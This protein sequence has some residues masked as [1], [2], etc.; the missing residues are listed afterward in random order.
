MNSTGL[1]VLA[2][3]DDRVVRRLLRISLSGHGMSLV[4]AETGAIGLDRLANDAPDLVVLD[5]GLPD[6]NGL[7]VLRH[8]RERSNIPIVVLSNTASV[9]AKIEALDLG[10]SDFVTKPFNVEEFAARLRVALRHRLQSQGAASLFRSGG[11][12]VDLVG[13]SVTRDGVAIRLSRTEFAV[14]R[15][16]VAHAGKVLTHEQILTEVWAHRRTVDYLRVYI[17]QLRKRLEIDPHNPQYVLTI[18]GVGY[19][20]TPS[21]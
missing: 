15:L 9:R 13:R 1:K 14:L 20:L 12:V 18:P 10:A 5:L 8:I 19:Q 21:E 2:I 6:Y 7:T 11:L 17:R 4:D 16:L 3:E